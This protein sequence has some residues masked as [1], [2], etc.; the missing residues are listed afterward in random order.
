MVVLGP[1]TGSVDGICQRPDSRNRFYLDLNT[2]GMRGNI[3][4]KTFRWDHRLQIQYFFM[5]FKRVP[6]T[7]VQQYNIGE[8]PT[9]M[10]YTYI[11]RH[12]GTRDQNETETLYLHTY[13]K[14]LIIIIYIN[15]AIDPKQ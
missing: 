4:V 13:L 14:R 10:L 5:A 6:L 12:P 3:N 7:V 15:S 9:V 11:N 2:K 1:K 8:K